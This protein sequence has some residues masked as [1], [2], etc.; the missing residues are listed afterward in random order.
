MIFRAEESDGEVAE[1]GGFTEPGEDFEVG[2]IGILAIES[3]HIG[4]RKDGAVGVDADAAHVEGDL[5]G[6]S[7]DTQEPPSLIFPDGP[8]LTDEGKVALNHRQQTKLSHAVP[9]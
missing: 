3:D 6:V 8:Q 9:E 4:E 2:A 7:G 5:L 1:L